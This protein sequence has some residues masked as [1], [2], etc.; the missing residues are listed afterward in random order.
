MLSF[1][2]VLHDRVCFE[3]NFADFSDVVRVR[4]YQDFI[5]S[6]VAF[7]ISNISYSDWVHAGCIQCKQSVGISDKKKNNKTEIEYITKQVVFVLFFP[8]EKVHFVHALT[9]IRK[10]ILM[11]YLVN[12]PC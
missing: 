3:N 9:N 1:T 5:R 7:P 10:M 8:R 11:K 2:G 12:I 6:L 4:K